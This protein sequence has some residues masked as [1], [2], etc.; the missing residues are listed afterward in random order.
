VRFTPRRTRGAEKFREQEGIGRDVRMGRIFTIGK[1]RILLFT[2]V[3]VDALAPRRPVRSAGDP[4][5]VRTT[6]TPST[7]R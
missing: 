1:R 2:S 4:A 6:T 5:A 7:L 3:W